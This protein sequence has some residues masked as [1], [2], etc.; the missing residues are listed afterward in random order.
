LHQQAETLTF[1]EVLS[2]SPFSPIVRIHNW[3]LM[4]ANAQI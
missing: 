2:F 1:T 3:K 4:L